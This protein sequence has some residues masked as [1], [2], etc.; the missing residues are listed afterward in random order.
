MRDQIDQ[1]AANRRLAAGELESAMP[2]MRI[3]A[4]TTWAI[5]SKVSISSFGQPG[6]AVF[7]HAIKA[8][9]IAAIGDADPQNA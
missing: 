8:A 2:W 6:D 4:F 1:T 9:I 3:A 7:G 5:S